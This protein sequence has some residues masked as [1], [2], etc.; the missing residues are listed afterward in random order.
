MYETNW[1]AALDSNPE[2]ITITSWN[3]WY[4]G[5]QIEPSATYNNLYLDLTRKWTAKF[6]GCETLNGHQ[7]CGPFLDYWKGHGGLAQQGYPISEQ[8][9][10]ASLTDP[11][12]T[13]LVQYFE[14]AIFE[15]HPENPPPYDILIT[16]LGRVRY[17]CKYGGNAPN[18]KPNPDNPRVFA[19]TGHQVGGAFRVY[20]ESHGGLAQQGYPLSDEFQE[21][22]DLDPGKTYIV[23]YFERGVF[24]FH[25]DNPAPFN[26]L[27]AQL[28]TYQ[29]RKQ[30]CPR[31]AGVEA[32]APAV[33]LPARQADFQPQNVRFF[34]SPTQ[35]CGAAPQTTFKVGQMVYA[36]LAM[37]EAPPG[38]EI[39][40]TWN[41][42]A[43]GYNHTD[44][45]VTAKY[46]KPVCVDGFSL[47]PSRY[48]IGP[49][50]YTV[51][52]SIAGA[53]AGSVEITITN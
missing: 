24:E 1:Q 38:I 9:T 32:P 26:V 29:Q 30:L 23:Q 11:G 41:G 39:A 10:E 45:Q 40:I 42:G 49:G 36:Q 43:H 46:Y 6:K 28:G 31:P 50:R 4:E 48:G 21:Q 25:P 13:Y 2:W 35:G 37:N 17:N 18:Q 27:L 22:S 3:E 34:T 7:V 16:Q 33:Q 52:L 47:Q 53:K 12:K 19:E 5:T 8:F 15:Q 51:S 20:W 44:T 14:R